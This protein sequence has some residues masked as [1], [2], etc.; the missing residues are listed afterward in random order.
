MQRRLAFLVACVATLGIPG[1]AR[2]QCT[3]IAWRSVIGLTAGAPFAASVRAQPAAQTADGHWTML[4][5]ASILDSS[6]TPTSP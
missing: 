3:E 4:G 2:G 6:L 5:A 1:V